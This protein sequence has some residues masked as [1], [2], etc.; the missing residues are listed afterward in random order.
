MEKTVTEKKDILEET[1]KSRIKEG[2][3]FRNGWSDVFRLI[4]AENIGI[5]SI[6]G[7]KQRKKLK[8][9]LEQYAR[10]EVAKN[11]KRMIICSE[12]Y[13]NP[14][15]VDSNVEGRGRNGRFI[16]RIIP[17]LIDVFRRGNRNEYDVSVTKLA[18]ECG[19]VN[20]YYKMLN[21]EEWIDKFECPKYIINNFRMI[22][23]TKIR[24]VLF[25]ALDRLRDYYNAIIYQN[26]YLLFYYDDESIEVSGK[27]DDNNRKRIREKKTIKVYAGEE[28]YEG[29]RF[30]EKELLK[31]Y[32]EQTKSGI[33]LK[34]K[35]KAY[36]AEVCELLSA[37]RMKEYVKYLPILK[38]TVF[39]EQLN[40]LIETP[41]CKQKSVER[42][43]SELREEFS[44]CI[45]NRI[46]QDK[47]RVNQKAEA[48]INEYIEMILEKNEDLRE[49]IE[50]LMC[51][52]EEILNQIPEKQRPNPFRYPPDYIDYQNHLR[53]KM[54]T[55]LPDEIEEKLVE[56]G[57]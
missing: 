14:H 31:K 29:I 49:R 53:W 56:D 28:I 2:M 46:I 6:G 3:V 47:D 20:P 44:M 40:K 9:R 35:G 22:C 17:I 18:I 54:I 55:K 7:G 16:D 1:V 8:E 39:H 26:G 48:T 36:Y 4:G 45:R 11:T 13:S 5:K 15:L 43:K 30:I 25:R 34:K 24:E 57:S 51:T 27:H 12:V 10:F 38:I 41:F 23:G 19:L 50:T 32:G 37:S 52:R 21:N 42:L 33:V